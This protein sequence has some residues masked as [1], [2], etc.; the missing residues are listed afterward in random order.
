MIIY[1]FY[2]PVTE[3]RVFQQVSC[4][5]RAQGLLKLKVPTPYPVLLCI[6]LCFSSLIIKS[7]NQT[8]T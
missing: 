3:M 1:H 7:K 2:H 6:T 8:T 5:P 4:T